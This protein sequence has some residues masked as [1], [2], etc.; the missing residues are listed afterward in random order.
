M[1]GEGN[2]SNNLVLVSRQFHG[3]SC[4][5]AIGRLERREEG[6]L[7]RDISFLGGQRPSIR[8]AFFVFR[9]WP[10]LDSYYRPS[11]IYSTRSISEVGR[12]YGSGNV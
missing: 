10:E 8:P 11:E 1:A 2:E 5:M 12:S 6:S 3:W 7:P 4:R 9:S